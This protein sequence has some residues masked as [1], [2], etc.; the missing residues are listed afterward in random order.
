[1]KQK[2]LWATVVVSALLVFQGTAHAASFNPNDII[3]N[4]VFDNVGSMNAP[5]IDTF[6]NQ[7]PSSCIS[8]NNGFQAPD[9]S[10]YNPTNGFLYGSNVSAGQVIY[11]SA[12]AYGINPQ[13]LLT[14]LEKEQNLVTGNAGCSTLRY[15]AAAGYGCP[16][17]GTTYNYSGVNLY[18]IHGTTITSV[19]GTC[20]DTAL[21]VGFS[22]QVVR[23][24]WLLKFGEQRSQG[25]INW[26]IVK[27]NWDNS[28]DPQSCYAGP[29]TQ[30][31]RQVC[32]SG[33]ISYYDGYIT[34]DSTSVHVDTGAT[35]ALYWYTPHFSGNQNFD[36]I[37]T[38]WFGSPFVSYTLVQ[39]SGNAAIYLWDGPTETIYLIPS[40][41]YLQALGLST[42]SVDI[43]DPSTL[44]YLTD[45]GTLTTLVRQGDGT[46]YLVESGRRYAVAG[47]STCTTWGLSCFD[48]SKVHTLSDTFLNS[49]IN[50]GAL[51][52]LQENNSTVYLMQNGQKSPVLN[53]K[54]LTNLGYGWADVAHM[55]DINSV[56]AL[57]PLLVPNGTAVKY[58]SSD[59]IYLYD[60]NA[61]HAISDF[62]LLISWGLIS[63]LVSSPPPSSYDTAQPAIDNLSL[64]SIYASD[65]THTY[66]IDRGTKKDVTNDTTNWPVTNVVAFP[67]TALANLPAA[68]SSDV[69]RDVSSGGIFTMES[70][71]KRWIPTADD[72]FALNY[73]ASQIVDISDYAASQI[74]TGSIKLAEGTLFRIN[75]SAAI[76]ILNNSQSVVIPNPSYFGYYNFNA[77]KINDFDSS[78]LTAYPL[79]ATALTV[80]VQNQS[81]QFFVA[82]NRQLYGLP[83]SAISSWG[84]STNG[85]TILSQQVFANIPSES[86]ISSFARTPD[87][88]IYFGSGG[89]AHKIGSYQTFLN[90]G[91]S[92]TNTTNVSADFISDCVMGGSFN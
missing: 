62:N 83:V 70:G 52:A 80:I 63:T 51:P 71:K 53:P 61:Y 22:Q 66:F 82:A 40:P 85:S 77:N 34:I 48:G 78:V 20:V 18:S 87:G 39:A 23:A 67:T 45:G 64:N 74:P 31:E 21:K 84:V 76:Y 12:Q 6:L 43:V 14:T 33:P 15:A 54:E 1:M 13:V 44:Q 79:A 89:A 36:T 27:G 73:K 49:L 16:D 30:G 4:A 17:G 92:T 69:V 81:G 8:S 65:G 29:V 2:I 32:P 55:S 57:G 75:S 5:Q 42:H 26:A 11:D 9:P 90:L 56:Q 60:N 7:F 91:G 28:D 41:A 38:G 3:D 47:S 59:T 58:R 37:F 19:S 35:A 88:T 72:F 86:T 68:P 25:N 10:G 50:A 46:I 24:A